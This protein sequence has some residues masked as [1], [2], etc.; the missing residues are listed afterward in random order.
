MKLHANA[1]LSWSARRRLAERVVVEGWTLTGAA[2]AAAQFVGFAEGKRA[3]PSA[4][5]PPATHLSD[6]SVRSGPDPV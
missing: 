3:P 5:Q 4:H 6:V 2:E 1:A